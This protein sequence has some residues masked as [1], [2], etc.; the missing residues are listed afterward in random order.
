MAKNSAEQLVSLS[1]IEELLTLESALSKLEQ[2][3]PQLSEIVMLKYFSGQTIEEI[4]NQLGISVSTVKREWNTA[5]VWL[6]R[7]MNK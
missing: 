2:F 5:K 4:A 1:C 7:E 3:D 6:H